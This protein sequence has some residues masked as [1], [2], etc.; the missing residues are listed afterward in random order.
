MGPWRRAALVVGT[1][2]GLNGDNTRSAFE[3]FSD[4]PSEVI[5][6]M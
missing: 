5:K 6:G 4:V 1:G 3:Y 2:M